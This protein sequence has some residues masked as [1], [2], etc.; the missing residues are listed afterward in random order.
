MV[1][2]R[3]VVDAAEKIVAAIEEQYRAPNL[4]LDE[5][6]QLAERGELNVF[7]EFSEACRHELASIP[8]PVR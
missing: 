3:R 6:R 4:T 1:A 7:L 5:F 8:G 2:S